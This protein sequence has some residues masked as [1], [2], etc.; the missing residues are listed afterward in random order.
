MYPSS[1]VTSPCFAV[2]DVLLLLLLLQATS[3]MPARC[4]RALV[5]SAWQG[6]WMQQTR[7]WWHGGEPPC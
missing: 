4:S 3:R 7:T 1:R 2:T 5:R 6:G